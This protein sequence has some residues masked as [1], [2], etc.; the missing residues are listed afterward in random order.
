MAVVG[1]DYW[2][3]KINSFDREFDS[4][5]TKKMNGDGNIDDGGIRRPN[6][7]PWEVSWPVRIDGS[8]T[9]RG[10]WGR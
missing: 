9:A 7:G 8:G 4:E 10:G 3:G 6:A 5:K 2:E 1:I